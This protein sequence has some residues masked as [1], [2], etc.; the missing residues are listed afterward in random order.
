VP[1]ACASPSSPSRRP[2]RLATPLLLSNPLRLG[3]TFSAAAVNFLLEH[4]ALIGNAPP[5]G[6]GSSSSGGTGAGAAAGA[7]DAGTGAPGGGGGAAAAAGASGAAAAP[8][9]A[10]AAAAS[11]P[12]APAATRGERSG[13]ILRRASTPVGGTC[14]GAE[15]IASE[16]DVL[17]AVLSWTEQA[18]LRCDDCRRLHARSRCSSHDGSDAPD[19]GAAAPRA[20]SAP[21]MRVGSGQR[22]APSGGGAAAAAAAGDGDSAR[23]CRRHQQLLCGFLCRLNLQL[24]EPTALEAL[25][26]AGLVSGEALVAAYRWSSRCLHAALRGRFRAGAG[27]AGAPAPP[28]GAPGGGGGGAAGGG[29]GG[30]AVTLCDGVFS[31][32]KD[33]VEVLE[34][35]WAGG[36][37]REPARVFTC[38]FPGFPLAAAQGP[39]R[40]PTLDPCAP[41][42]PPPAPRAQEPEPP[43]RHDVGATAGRQ[44]R[45]DGARAL[46]V[47]PGVAGRVGRHPGG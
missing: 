15:L 23:Y 47:R 21:P 38:P 30:G 41:P 6:G 34:S 1:A 36:T 19:A 5:S 24:L 46:G 42:P 26:A 45:V 20:A 29:S 35:R 33:G 4:T 18:S 7:P 22:G 8:A 14:V 44:A 28:G 40:R 16:A 12:G 2:A 31:H 37:Q 17:K 39:G 9:P 3:P 25:E 11:A 13:S 10:A 43:Q 32:T 27:G